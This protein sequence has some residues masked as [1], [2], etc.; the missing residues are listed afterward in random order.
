MSQLQGSKPRSG[1]RGRIARA[2]R[3]ALPAG[4]QLRHAPVS[5]PE[6]TAEPASDAIGPGAWREA[7]R[8]GLFIIGHARSGTTILQNALN[9]SADIF[10]LGEPNLHTDPG[11]PD[12][13]QRY[14]AMQHSFHNQESKSSYCPLFFPEDAAWPAYLQQLLENYRYVG[15]KIVV[16]PHEMHRDVGRLFD[17]QARHF[18]NSHYLFCFRDPETV[19]LSASRLLGIDDI[20]ALMLSYLSVMRLYIRMLR[21]FRHVLVLFHEEITSDSFVAISRLLGLELDR[22]HRYYSAGKIQRYRSEEIPAGVRPLLDEIQA[23]YR[24]FK[25]G[26]I[27]GFELVQ[28]Q[29]HFDRHDNWHPTPLGEHFNRIEEL[30][31][32]LSEP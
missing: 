29:Q 12:F 18:Y 2:V 21:N 31:A 10:L 14:N 4:W 25:Q 9:D 7:S 17:F 24:E 23:L 5:A 27:A 20:R 3:T 32:A 26:A 11:T 19:I 28:I 22:C 16:T 13:A 8:R 15:A 6:A 30:M 1:Y